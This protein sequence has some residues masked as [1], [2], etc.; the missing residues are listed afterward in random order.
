MRASELKAL[1][2]S[3][4]QEPHFF[5]RK[6]MRFFGDTMSNYGVRET[7]ID[8]WTERDVPVYELYRRHAVKHGLTDSA[9]FDKR[10]FERRHA[11]FDLTTKGGNDHE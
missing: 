9:Y 10:T 8:T 11:K 5:S 4:G 7:V 2:E 1:V 3:H 6:T